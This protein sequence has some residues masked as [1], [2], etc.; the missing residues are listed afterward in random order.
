MYWGSGSDPVVW[1]IAMADT[2]QR[3]QSEADVAQV[4]AEQAAY[5]ELQ[6][7]LAELSKKTDRATRMLLLAHGIR[8]QTRKGKWVKIMQ[9]ARQLKPHNPQ[10]TQVEEPTRELL[11]HLAKQA[12]RGSR[13]AAERLRTILKENP[14]FSKPMGDLAQHAERSLIDM[15]AGTNILFKESLWLYVQELREALQAGASDDPLDGLLIS[16]LVVISLE[17]QFARL[18]AIQPQKYLRDA[19]H[20]EQRHELASARFLAAIRQLVFI[21]QLLGGHVEDLEAWGQLVCEQTRPQGQP[22]EAEN[23]EQKKSEEA[24]A[25]ETPGETAAEDGPDLGAGI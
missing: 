13:K 4:R 8:L 10:N 20:W 22:A 2:L 16:H 14:Q 25:E 6:P 1:A 18:A 7:R 9:D 12:N 17:M 11:N 5:R 21:R 23:T 19:R 24:E 15:I 3:Q